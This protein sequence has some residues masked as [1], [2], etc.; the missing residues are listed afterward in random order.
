MSLAALK[1]AAA[2]PGRAVAGRYLL[3]AGIL[4][5]VWETAQ[6][7]LYTIWYS[8]SAFDMVYAVIHCTAGDVIILSA[9]FFLSL[10]LL[11][12]TAWPA[13]SYFRVALLVTFLGAACTIYSEQ[14]NV[15]V[16]KNWAYA[17]AMPLLPPL[18][19]GLSPLLQW[20]LIPIP[21]FLLA[22]RLSR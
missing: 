13:R 7:P 14:L 5:L 4:N 12:K 19:T 9:T 18:G 17:P 11:G 21:A 15:N 6:L 22:R 2:W 10:L 1:S 20:L 3:I 16:W 8:G